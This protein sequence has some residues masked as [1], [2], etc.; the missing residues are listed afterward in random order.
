M[1]KAE[2]VLFVVDD[3]PSMRCSHV[4][5]PPSRSGTA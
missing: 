4:H 2:Q 3:D 5:P 1:K